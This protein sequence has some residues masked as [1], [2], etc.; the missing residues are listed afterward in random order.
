MTRDVEVIGEQFAGFDRSLVAAIDQDDAFARQLTSGK[1]GVGS[2]AA[3]SK[4]AIFGP[5]CAPSVG[6]A[7]RLAEVDEIDGPAR[8]P[9]S[10]VEQRSLLGAADDQRSLCL[11][12]IAK[13]IELGPAQLT[14][15]R[16][17]AVA[18]STL[19][20]GRYRG[21][22]CLRTSTSGSFSV[23]PP[24]AATQLP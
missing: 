20:G 16:D 22:S 7:G 23:D 24:C 3:A 12:C 4:A 1:S 10:S 11:R 2:A 9:A 13:L 19:N 21:A 15:G 6:P 18:A 17:L 5:A 14:E 8:S